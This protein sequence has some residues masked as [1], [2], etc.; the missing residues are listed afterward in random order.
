MN[1]CTLQSEFGE[2]MFVW[3]RADD[4]VLRI[5][6]PAQ[7]DLFKASCYGAAI[8]TASLPRVVAGLCRKMERL[9]E[10]RAVNFDL[11]VLDWSAA[12][13]FQE[14]VLRVENRIPRGMVSTY[15]RIAL[16]LRHPRAARAV[17]S[18]LARNPFPLVI[19]CHR[20]IRNDRTLGGYAGGLAMKRRLLEWE[21]V[22]FDAS[23]RVATAT[24][25]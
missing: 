10:G 3:R 9:L 17:G 22:K 4:R 25:W 20:A 2:L 13:R 11:D 19:P 14:R 16:R 1:Y 24:F 12:G 23:G 18:A 15:G 5:F 7:R 6:L 8:F 21:G